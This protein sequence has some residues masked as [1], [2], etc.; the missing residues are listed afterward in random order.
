[1]NHKLKRT[2][3]S[4]DPLTVTRS[5]DISTTPHLIFP[6]NSRRIY[7]AVKLLPY[8]DLCT[9]MATSFLYKLFLSTIGRMP[10]QYD[11]KVDSWWGIVLTELGLLDPFREEVSV[12]IPR[13]GIKS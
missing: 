1:M 12:E 13:F 8:S 4:P 10:P 3:K 7:S 11:P 9:V 5:C 6:S 2:T